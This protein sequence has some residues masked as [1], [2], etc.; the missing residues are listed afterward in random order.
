MEA[1]HVPVI[2]YALIGTP[3]ADSITSMWF[4][5]DGFVNKWEPEK[6][7]GMH[8]EY[9]KITSWSFLGID[10]DD[11]NPGLAVFKTKFSKAGWNFTTTSIF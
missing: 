2:T 9:G 7:T 3:A 8:N 4:G 5:I 11:P 1:E 6:V 10:K